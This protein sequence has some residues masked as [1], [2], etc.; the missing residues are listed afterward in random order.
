MIDAIPID[1]IPWQLHTFTYKGQKPSNNA[2]K[3]MTGEYKIFYQDPHRIFT[4][5]LENPEFA[6]DIDYA[7]LRQYDDNG[8]RQYENFMSGDWA[9]KQAVSH[10]SFTFFN[11]N[12]LIYPQDKIGEKPKNKGSLFVLIILGSDKTT[13]SIATGHNKYWPLYGSIGNI[14][15]NM[16]QAHGA[17]FVL[18]GF[19]AIAKGMST[20]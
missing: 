7:P 3:W 9:W 13:V 18:I 14:H 8:V 16:R 12:Q 10:L 1:G 5:M 11:S 17:G 20:L 6:K 15:N 2:P 19:L 4:D